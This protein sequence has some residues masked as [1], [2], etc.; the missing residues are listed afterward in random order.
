MLCFPSLM[1]HTYVHRSCLQ[2]SVR[3]ATSYSATASDANA[4]ADTLHSPCSMDSNWTNTIARYLSVTSMNC[5][6]FMRC[7]CATLC[8]GTNCPMF[9]RNSIGLIGSFSMWDMRPKFNLQCRQCHWSRNIQVKLSLQFVSRRWSS[10]RWTRSIPQTFTAI[11]SFRL[12]EKSNSE[13]L[14]KNET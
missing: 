4:N 9:L 5:L 2:F 13:E 7:I 14:I 8:A 1:W 10:R 12:N 11:T 3:L 6:L